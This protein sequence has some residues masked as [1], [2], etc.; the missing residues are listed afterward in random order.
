VAIIVTAIQL[1]ASP[2]YA[3]ERFKSY[4]GYDVFAP[5]SELAREVTRRWRAR[6]SSPLPIVIATFDIAAP[7]VFY[8]P[9]HPRMFAD[10]PDPPRTFAA[11]QPEF[12][13][14]I[15]Y[16]A[17]LRR[18]GFVGI[19]DNYDTDCVAYLDRLAPAAEALDVTLTREVAGRT[20]V[21]W[22]F[23]LRIMRP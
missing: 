21:P 14:W 1:V 18:L 20:A 23:H 8:S 13:P 9:D 16:P 5:T 11:D 15:D 12:S 17:D 22:T 7:V 19:C 4:P 6:F 10:S 3:Y 2:F